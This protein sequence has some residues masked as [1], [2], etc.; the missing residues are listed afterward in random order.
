[1]V[2]SGSLDESD[3]SWRQMTPRQEL[4]NAL[5]LNSGASRMLEAARQF[6]I[7]STD[8]TWNPRL[9][10]FDNDGF[11]DLFVTTGVCATR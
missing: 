11:V 8:W 7:D 6:H 3:M 1:M 4:R 10:D 9:A 2:M 5:Y